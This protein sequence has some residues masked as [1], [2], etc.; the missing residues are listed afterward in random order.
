M[1]FNGWVLKEEAVKASKS[2]ALRGWIERQPYKK[3]IPCILQP[4]KKKF[5]KNL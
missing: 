3:F 4:G 2:L 5:F 1:R